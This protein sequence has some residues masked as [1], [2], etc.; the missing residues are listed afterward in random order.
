MVDR[1]TAFERYGSAGQGTTHT[2]VSSLVGMVQAADIGR[3]TDRA[4]RLTAGRTENSGSAVDG[5]SRLFNHGSAVPWLIVLPVSS[6][7]SG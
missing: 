1:L 3:S 6:R 5:L 7:F 2:A 4:H